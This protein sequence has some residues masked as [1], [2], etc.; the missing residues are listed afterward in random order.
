MPKPAASAIVTTIG[1]TDALN[2]LIAS[3][4]GQK[5][6]PELV[7]LDAS[8]QGSAKAI[9]KQNKGMLS[10]Q[11]VPVPGM[12]ASEARNIG[13]EKAGSDFLLFTD[14]DCVPKKG[15]ASAYLAAFRRGYD[16]VTGMT[17]RGK[18]LSPSVRYFSEERECTR[19]D[20][21]DPV[22]QSSGNNWACR[23]DVFLAM[24]GFDGRFGPGAKYRAAE[25]LELMY[26]LIKSGK[27]VLR[28]PK[29]VVVHNAGHSD[30]AYEGYAFG[31]GGFCRTH[32]FEL[33]PIVAAKLFFIKRGLEI[34]FY[35]SLS[36]KRMLSFFA[37]F[38]A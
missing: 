2:D 24:K 23:K 9:A 26:R 8:S 31:L 21:F 16:A 11:Y 17:V 32:F 35:P 13:A 4:S 38:L 20:L 3:L 5:P 6:K 10:I 33:Y 25:D 29:P 36:L 19:S 7:L 30:K 37:G 18:P 15:W 1:N 22:K 28:S 27:K 34:P 12:G 14:D